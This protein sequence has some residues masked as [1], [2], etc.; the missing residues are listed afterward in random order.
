MKKATPRARLP[1]LIALVL[2]A[3]AAHA[4]SLV[5]DNFT[6]SS[7]GWT[8]V[9]T[10]TESAGVGTYRA[11]FGTNGLSV[12]TNLSGFGSGNALA[13]TNSTHTTYRSFNDA[14]T[15]TLNSLAT[16]ET[17]RI[18]F[19]I[20]FDGNFGGSQNFSLGLVNTTAPS[21]IVYANVDLRT[22]GT[23]QSEFR[24]R[25]GSFNMSDAGLII[26]SYNWTEPLCESH[27]NA[28]MKLEV[29]RVTN[30]FTIS[31]FK[32]GAVAGALTQTNGS[33][34]ANAM[35]NTNIT[36]IAFRHSQVPGLLT[37][38]DNVEVTRVEAGGG[39]AGSGSTNT[40]IILAGGQVQFGFDIVSGAVY[41][42]EATSDLL[43]G[44]SWTNITEQ[45]TN[46][47]GDALTFIDTNDAAPAT[48]SY[49]IVS[50]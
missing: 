12:A 15:L 50:P 30:G 10:D 3:G 13:I 31:Y 2:A 37:Y 26:G 45:L 14:A 42:V 5:S 22:N 16:N 1:L 27:S 7:S 29:T 43:D 35:A 34:W 9:V 18:A 4:S 21:S 19:D 17:L 48:R 38:L 40:T 47:L 49:R 24:Y 25:S 41:R 20:R 33:V 32:D 44:S 6:A 36:G 11:V 23:P 8:G 28:T 46:E 39:P